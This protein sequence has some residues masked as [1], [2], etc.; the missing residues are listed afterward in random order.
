VHQRA[1]ALEN[2]KSSLRRSSSNSTRDICATHRKAL[3][4]TLKE[5]IPEDIEGESEARCD[6]QNSIGSDREDGDGDG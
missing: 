6:D 2:I 3:E 1:L 5:D 4:G